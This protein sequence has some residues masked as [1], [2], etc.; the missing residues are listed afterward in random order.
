A[1]LRGVA[2][3]AGGDLPPGLPAAFAGREASRLGRPQVRAPR[4]CRAGHLS[5][6]HEALIR[7]MGPEDVAAVARLEAESYAFPWTPG[8]FR[9]CLR[10]GYYC[11]VAE[12][13]G[14]CI[15]YGIMSVGAGEAHV[16][17]I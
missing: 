12:D 2:H 9:D 14:D 1:R 11:C 7:D 16:L 13:E 3:S 6:Q 8:I 5:V 10:A 17:N 4:G 15:G